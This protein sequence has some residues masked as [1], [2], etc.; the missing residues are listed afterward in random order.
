VC[1]AALLPGSI[2]IPANPE[3]LWHLGERHKGIEARDLDAAPPNVQKQ[4]FLKR[5]LAWAWWNSFLSDVGPCTHMA[6][7]PSKTLVMG[8]KDVFLMGVGASFYMTQPTVTLQD[9]LQPGFLSP[10]VFQ[11]RR[12]TMENTKLEPYIT[13]SLP[14]R[15]MVRRDPLSVN[16]WW[17]AVFESTSGL[18]RLRLVAL[19]DAEL[20]WVMSDGG[21]G[22]ECYRARLGVALRVRFQGRRKDGLTKQQI[23][24]VYL[25]SAEPIASVGLLSSTSL[26]PHEVVLSQA[27]ALAH[28]HEWLVAA[29]VLSRTWT[30]SQ[31]RR[32]DAAHLG[33]LYWDSFT[34]IVRFEVPA[35]VHKPKPAVL[36]AVL[37]AFFFSLWNLRGCETGV[38]PG[39]CY[40][41]VGMPD[42][43]RLISGTAWRGVLATIWSVKTIAQLTRDRAKHDRDI[44]AFLS[45]KQEDAIVPLV[46]PRGFLDEEAKLWTAWHGK[47]QQNFETYL[48]SFGGLTIRG[49]QLSASSEL[50]A[51]RAALPTPPLHMLARAA[52]SERDAMDVDEAPAPGEV[53]HNP[54]SVPVAPQAREPTAE[55]AR[56]VQ[57]MTTREAVQAG[58]TNTGV[59]ETATADEAENG[60][61]A[62]AF[63][64]PELSS[65]L[66]SQQTM[67]ISLRQWLRALFTTSAALNWESLRS[68]PEEDVRGRWLIHQH[69][70]RQAVSTFG[71]LQSFPRTPKW[72]LVC[73]FTS[74][75][76]LISRIMC[77]QE[78]LKD[79]VPNSGDDVLDSLRQVGQIGSN[80]TRDATT[81]TLV[82]SRD[83]SV[84]NAVAMAVD[85][86]IREHGTAAAKAVPKLTAAT[87]KNWFPD[88]ARSAVRQ[89]TLEDRERIAIPGGARNTVLVK[90]NKGNTIGTPRGLLVLLSGKEGFVKFLVQWVSSQPSN[91]TK[92]SNDAGVTTSIP[93]RHIVYDGGVSRPLVSDACLVCRAEPRL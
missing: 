78:A 26:Q 43:D 68:A 64:A 71:I 17:Y 15:L 66:A 86:Y 16:D 92:C 40:S 5:P 47:V 25:L 77:G 18:P 41:P 73:V 37:G 23:Q 51:A 9:A 57:K 45:Q 2:L 52:V 48:D 35:L 85:A 24:L 54:P 14:S 53:L 84:C 38:D 62:L 90:A 83:M 76:S 50:M 75:F 56:E 79:V 10:W 21:D 80:L 55:L 59:F 31:L 12:A 32:L 3:P 1:R 28:T 89:S 44:L 4:I 30:M 88:A 39:M 70:V 8:V 42:I 49:Q 67:T 93:V 27:M 81:E 69:L 6:S 82:L 87:V 74:L 7:K 34:Y 19:V 46:E 11:S 33:Q 65:F 13:S 36:V 63:N 29:G 20:A 91:V 61:R 22:K 60:A 72:P 58:L